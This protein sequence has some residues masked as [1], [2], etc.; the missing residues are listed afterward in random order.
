[1]AAFWPPNY[2]TRV[3]ETRPATSNQLPFQEKKTSYVL[4][5]FS[6]LNRPKESGPLPF[7][8]T[9]LI[10]QFG[11]SIQFFR[12]SNHL[13][14]IE[15]SNDGHLTRLEEFRTADGTVVTA[16]EIEAN[17]PVGL[18]LALLSCIRTVMLAINNG[19]SLSPQCI[20]FL[21]SS[22]VSTIFPIYILISSASRA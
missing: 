5:S 21:S 9:G 3:S 2:C 20:F 22:A 15:N 7:G 11:S 18:R 6:I 4:I 14:A 10:F 8:K 19:Q 1:M 17:C 13:D 12:W 16:R